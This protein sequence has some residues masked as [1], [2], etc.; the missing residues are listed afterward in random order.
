MSQLL[1]EIKEALGPQ[2]K[3]KKD[4]I[5]KAENIIK[6]YYMILIL[7]V[8]AAYVLNLINL[9]NL[10]ITIIIACTSLFIFLI[11]LF[12]KVIYPKIKQRELTSP[13][14]SGRLIIIVVIGLLAIVAAIFIINNI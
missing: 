9:I 7:L 5:E 10:E 2:S 8:G 6:P 12:V 13:G 4:E 11:L 3:E 1:K 14:L